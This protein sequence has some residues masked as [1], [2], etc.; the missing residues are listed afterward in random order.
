MVKIKMNG[1]IFDHEQFHTRIAGISFLK[2]V[3]SI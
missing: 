1:E 3:F 2:K